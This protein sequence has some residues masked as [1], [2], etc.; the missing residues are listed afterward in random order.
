MTNIRQAHVPL[1]ARLAVA[2]RSSVQAPS[3]PAPSGTRQGSAAP[4]L[5][6]ESQPMMMQ[7]APA[8]RPTP[9]PRSTY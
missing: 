5:Q 2:G 7:N 6:T 1:P 9:Q 8:T 3:G 4:P